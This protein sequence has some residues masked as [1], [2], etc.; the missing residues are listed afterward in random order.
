MPG[1]NLPSCLVGISSLRALAGQ[2]SLVCLRCPGAA[3]LAATGAAC[4]SAHLSG[5]KVN[6]QQ[7]LVYVLLAQL[8]TFTANVLQEQ[9]FVTLGFVSFLH[10][11]GN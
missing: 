10:H 7:V 5:E 3:F 11:V 2:K 4:S 1:E 6:D 9:S 8:F